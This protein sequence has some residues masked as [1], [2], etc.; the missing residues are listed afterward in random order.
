M[1]RSIAT[2]PGWDASPSQGYIQQ[3]VVCTHLY[4]LV[5]RDEEHEVLTARDT[6]LHKAYDE[7]PP[8]RKIPCSVL[9]GF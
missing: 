2:P 8:K 3:Y 1:P 7:H 5:K 6:R 9:T 4:T